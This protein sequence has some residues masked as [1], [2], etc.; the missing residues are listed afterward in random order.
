MSDETTVKKWR[1]PP[2]Y[3]T[4]ADWDR[5][6]Q[7]GENG[8]TLGQALAV[9]GLNYRTYDRHAL[10]RPE[11]R[12]RWEA[13]QMRGIE[14]ATRMLRQHVAEGDKS[15]L[16]FFLK[17]KASWNENQ[18]VID[19]LAKEIEELKAEIAGNK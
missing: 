4:E 19:K 17:C 11:I 1:K 16:M 3:P 9:L 10:K 18:Y 15:C 2:R 8:M 7:M 13:A 5:L 12:Q 14:F 6:E